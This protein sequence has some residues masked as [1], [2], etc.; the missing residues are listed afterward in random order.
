MEK[1]FHERSK[2]SL[3]T[4]TCFVLTIFNSL[5]T[6]STGEK[7]TAYEVLESYNFPIG[8]LPKGI[9]GYDLDESTG[10]FSAYLN[11]SCSFSLE[12]S[13]KLSYQ[14]T[15]K[16]YISQGKLSSLQGVKVKWLF[17]WVDIIEVYRR[18]DELEFSVGITSA[19]F[20]V[21]NFEECPQCGCGFNCSN[22][23]LRKTRRNSFG[24]SAY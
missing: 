12:D 4:L 15:I 2:L 21:D 13:Y 11:G 22:R 23:F 8:I 20:S 10:K 5:L 1:L 6:K 7:P 18:G 14:P 16:G 3:A 19:E 24:V 9:T 17:L